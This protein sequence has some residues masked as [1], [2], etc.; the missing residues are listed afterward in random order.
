MKYDH[1]S[2]EKKWQKKWAENHVYRTGDDLSNPKKAYILDMF[3]YPSGQGL[4]V[5]HPKGYIATDIIARKKKME[6][7][8]VLHPMGWDAFGLP[9]ENY[10]LKTK[11]HPKKST[12]D[13]VA[14]YKEQLSIIG[15][16]YDWEREIN[17]TD[18]AYYKWTQWAFVKML[19][20]GLAYESYE[21]I[22]WCPSCKTG[23]ANEDLDGNLCERC[24]SEVEKKPMRQWVIKITDYADRLLADLETLDWPESIKES[25]RNWI[26]RSEGAS[27]EFG[28][29]NHESRITDENINVFTTR[30]DTLFGCTYVVVAPEH[31]L[32]A[33]HEARIENQEDVT[34]YIEI[35]KKKTVIERTAEGKEKTGVRIDGLSAI[36]PLTGEE[37]PI[38][39]ADYVLGDYGTGAVMAVPAHDERDFAFATKFDLP[40]PRV[41]EPLLTQTEGTATFREDEPSVDS[42]GVIGL[43]KHWSEDKYI[44]LY[45]PSASWGTLLTG[46]I[47]EG[48]TPEETIL[49]EIREETGY[50]SA[51][52]VEYLG[53]IHSKYY[54]HPKA[55]NRIGHAR[56]FI[57]E[58][59]NGDQESVSEEE[60]KKHEVRWLTKDELK[61]FLTAT[62]HLQAVAYLD[63]RVYTGPG[64][65]TDSGEF[66]GLSSDEAR[67]AIVA[68]LEKKGLGKKTVNYKLRDWVFSRQ[69]YWGEPIPVVHCESCAAMEADVKLS[70]NF[71][72]EAIWKRLLSG[73]KTIE[74]RALN[75]DEPER[76][77]GDVTKGDLLRFVFKPTGEARLFRVGTIYRFEDVAELFEPE[78]RELHAKFF[79]REFESAEELEASYATLA[80]EYAERIRKNG[81]V[82]W[83]IEAVMT[84]KVVL[85]PESELPVLLPDVESYEPTGTGESPLAGIADWVNTTCPKCG[86]PAK[87]ETNTMPQWAGSSWYYLRYIDPHNTEK[88]VDPEKEKYWMPVDTYVGGAEHATRHLIYARFWHKFLHD[89]GVVSGNEPF[90]K[91]QHVGLIGGEDGRKMSKRFGN[92]INP[93]D[94]VTQYGA[95]TL[96]VYEMFMGPFDQNIAWGTD[97]IMGARRFLERVWKLAEKIGDATLSEDAETLLNRTIKKIGDDIDTF[98]FNTAISSLMILVNM[99]EKERVVS[100]EHYRVLLRLLAPFA[101][102]MSEELWTKCG[103]GGSIVC[104]PWPTYDETKLSASTA[105]IAVQVN[106]KIRATFVIPAGMGDEEVCTRALALPEAQKYIAG[107]KVTKTIVVPN[108][109]VSLVTD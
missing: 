36:H 83:E 24:G 30:A 51:R 32:I 45:W 93:D 52:I 20:K 40:M 98:A 71:R 108:K 103:D 92:V 15:L 29:K 67:H 87:R 73:E 97:N 102:H 60:T 61:A 95:D 101:P 64:I 88:L 38:F 46:G 3:P 42:D 19:E 82:G 68:T 53:V 107:K 104:A 17:T 86:G 54:H 74:T 12:D 13:N 4:H 47:D 79:S 41:I 85:V 81:L 62:S 28:I 58:L 6:G 89:I 18:P 84:D 16:S 96:R 7:Y 105:T 57:V 63:A 65:L 55:Q 25:Q 1:P 75:P 44:G 21:P 34:H 90:V 76:Y 109:L 91:L 106:G 66:S 56:T 10:A 31:E 49:K 35:T 50:T 23:L 27:I 43:V 48:E 26:G 77:F 37:L 5:G 70:L 22:N 100:V 8:N 14:R 69:R 9:A 78:N 99:F 59:Q 72:E 94:I 11:T 2:I 33:K 39:V 80:P